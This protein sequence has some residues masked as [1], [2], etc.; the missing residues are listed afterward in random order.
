MVAEIEVLDHSRMKYAVN[1]ESM[2]K[3]FQ[4]SNRIEHALIFRFDHSLADVF[5]LG[6]VMTFQS[7]LKPMRGIFHG[8]KIR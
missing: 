3:T 7:S 6:S 5:C 8:P 4:R 2:F 1:N